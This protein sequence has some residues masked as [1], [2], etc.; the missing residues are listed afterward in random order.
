MYTAASPP[1]HG[2]YFPFST[3][4]TVAP[5]AST[6]L[7]MEA[8]LAPPPWSIILQPAIFM[9]QEDKA[10]ISRALPLSVTAL[11]MMAIREMCPAYS[12]SY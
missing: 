8:S 2:N 3:P 4:C 10:H 11:Y 7:Y 6:P 5:P 1:Q 12:T 9:A